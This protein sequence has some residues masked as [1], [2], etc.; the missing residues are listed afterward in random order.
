M[1]NKSTEYFL[2]ANSVRG[3]YS[4]YDS[5][6]DPLAGDKLYII[7]GGPGGGKSG[8]MKKIASKAEEQG[9][10]AEY[11]YCS[12][13]PDSLD[14][15][16]F[17]E[18]K[19]AIVDGT[20]PHVT[21]PSHHGVT[22]FYID[23]G[24]FCHFSG[25]SAEIIRLFSEYKS[26]YSPAYDYLKRYGTMHSSV[27]PDLDRYSAKLAK[28]ASALVK[29]LGAGS[30]NPVEKSRFIS[31]ETYKGRIVLTKEI[32]NH[33]TV[34]ALSGVSGLAE[35]LC[36]FIA[37]EAR[38]RNI[39]ATLYLDPLFPDSI[40]AVSLPDTSVIFFARE[41]FKDASLDANR[42]IH[43]DN[44]MDKQSLASVKK[45]LKLSEKPELAILGLARHELIMAKSAHDKLEKAYNPYID[46]DSVSKLSAEYFEKIFS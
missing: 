1:K 25:S 19:A 27:M 9:F 30:L 12:G 4:C 23:L 15:V 6:T 44:L 10:A 28:R 13:D 40:I 17:P 32:E 46:F 29:K 34:I 8:F 11:V 18:R 16:Y 21:E 2:G 14:G 22:G 38:G 35:S 42:T 36:R 3:F 26:H 24:R 39:S 20:A 43:T 41:K 31:A 5:F 33:D 45:L 7:K 37:Y